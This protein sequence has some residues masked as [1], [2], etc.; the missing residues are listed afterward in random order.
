[1][2][3][4]AK[5][6]GSTNANVESETI[7]ALDRRVVG[8]DGSLA[9]VLL[10]F[11]VHEDKVGNPPS[12]GLIINIY[13]N[14]PN[15]TDPFVPGNFGLLDL[16]GGSGSPG[17]ATIRSWIE[18]GYPG[19]FELLPSGCTPVEGTP[20]LDNSLRDSVAMRIGE[21]VLVLVHNG[22]SGTGSNAVYSVV[23]LL[24]VKIVGVFGSGGNL[25]II[26]QIS[27]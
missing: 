14:R 8:F 18:S 4:F 26:V 5:V 11:A 3:C 24:A 23:S 7:A 12:I 17:R 1:L 6:L 25:Q 10:P 20:G 16:T 19:I 9:G 27:Q 13:P 2:L 15:E 21:T 22:V